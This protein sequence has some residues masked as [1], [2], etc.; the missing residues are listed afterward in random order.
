[1]QSMTGYGRSEVQDEQ[2]RFTIEMRS[3]NH[4]YLD[5]SL[6]YPRVYTPLET[7]M[8][9][10]MGGYFTRGRIEVTVAQQTLGASDRAVTLDQALA[11]Q[12]HRA[13]N[14]LQE[15]LRLPGT[16]DL[17]MLLTMREILKIEEVETDIEDV[18][19]LMQ[20]GFEQASEALQHMRLQEGAFLAED[21][22][23]RLQL[24]GRH[25]EAIR[26]RVP[27]VVTAYRG[28]LEERIAELFDTH[29]LDPDRLH[30]ET[31]LLAERTDVA[32]E[33][34]RLEAHLQAMTELLG[35]E[36]A[37]GRKIEFLLQ[38]I[39]REVNTIA[40]KSSD[41]EISQVVVEIKS[42]LERMREQ[43]QNVE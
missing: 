15:A 4:R 25:V 32:E 10:L 1:M 19:Q 13:L 43:I 17:N 23:T 39:N 42:E 20:T 31:I 40:S 7:R 8:K 18:W 16:V 9:Q 30:Q 12:Y 37:I 38:E 14:Q 6:R 11:Q 22:R 24:I 36:G 41:A 5:I 29:Q 27:L 34:T 33:L 21:L 26:Q 2:F 28:R 35:T 3:V